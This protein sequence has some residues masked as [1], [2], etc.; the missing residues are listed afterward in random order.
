MQEQ[1][2]HEQATTQP[3]DGRSAEEQ[4]LRDAL[5]DEL[6]GG[7]RV[8]S[9]E[10]YGRGALTGFEEAGTARAWYVD[11][12]GKRVD[13]E[14]GLVL[15]DPQQPQARIWLHPADPRLPALSPA[16]FP[17]AATTLMARMGVVI[18]QRPELL[19]YR[20]GKRA[21]FRMRE[22]V[23]ETYLKVVRP[24][25][26]A[27]IVHLQESL[28]A[29]GVPVPTITAWSE[30]GIVLTEAAAGV[31]LTARL[32]ELDP[33][34]LLDS[35]DA[36]RERMAAVD[37][38]RD[39][40]ASLASRTPWYVSRLRAALDRHDRRDGA[41]L[42]GLLASVERSLEASDA[43]APDDADRRTVH[44]DLHVG[45]LFV[46]A[47]GSSRIAGVIDIDTAGLGD[48]A[49]DEAAMIGHLVA[50]IALSRADP[51]RAAGFRRLLDASVARWLAPGRPGRG[52]VAHRTAVHVLAHALTPTERGDLE[53]AEA[54][55]A[56]GLEILGRGRSAGSGR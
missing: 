37:T 44:G 26:S 38:G 13:S 19:V 55:L 7:L 18:D 30:L 50:S 8:L 49:D 39:A 31:P 54:E 56:L 16:S 12:S 51:A 20:P 32:D 53:T 46:D 10:P 14:T 1:R 34:R 43:A 47:D 21:M 22:G 41:R 27:A 15:G 23:R 48:P 5:G 2:E 28:R 4:L 29:G 42:E 6:R 40:R 35:I 25:S 52:R 17:D 3:V 33:E 36:L 45:Q 11:T 9:H 24:S